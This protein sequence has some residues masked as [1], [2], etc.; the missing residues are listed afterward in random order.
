[1]PE[2]EYGDVIDPDDNTQ[3]VTW[4]NTSDGCRIQ[5]GGSDGDGYCYTHQRFECPGTRMTNEE[6]EADED[7]E[8]EVEEAQED[9]EVV[10][11]VLPKGKY[12]P[13][14]RAAHLGQE[15]CAE[16]GRCYEAGTAEVEIEGVKLGFCPTHAAAHRVIEEAIT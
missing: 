4:E 9:G 11:R 15:T 5:H 6:A 7:S 10:V 13:F 8:D 3:G 2:D 1:M 16:P 14:S 12:A